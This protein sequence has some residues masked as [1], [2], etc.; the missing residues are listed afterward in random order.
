L[1]ARPLLAN[2]CAIGHCPSCSGE[3][4]AGSIREI[5]TPRPS[6]QARCQNINSM[7]IE[8]VILWRIHITFRKRR[9]VTPEVTC[10]AVRKR[11]LLQQA[12]L[13]KH[14]KIRYSMKAG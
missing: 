12:T 5:K 11:I 9:Q 3:A 2:Q 1:A 10:I 7:L 13:G 14:S 6:P 4:K 8:R